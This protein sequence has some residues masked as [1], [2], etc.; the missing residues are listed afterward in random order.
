MLTLGFV[1]N[2]LAPCL[3]IKHI[4]QEYIIIAIYVD[5]ISIFGTPQ[6]TNETIA[7]LKA[8]FEMKDMGHPTYCLGIQIETLS[9]GIFI[10]QST[11]TRKVL[12]QFNM[13][14]AYTVTTPMDL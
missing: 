2:E 14:K 4:G 6:I 13:D 7:N 3:F 11:Y 10:H 9:G 1:N 5:D 8:T 12:I